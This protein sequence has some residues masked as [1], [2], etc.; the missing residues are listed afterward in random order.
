MSPCYGQLL[1]PAS[2]TRE[3][4]SAIKVSMKK[5]LRGSSALYTWPGRRARTKRAS[6]SAVLTEAGTF[7][8][9]NLW[10]FCVLG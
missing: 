4:T 10:C 5:S 1:W 3:S 7:R 2:T 8:V 9:L 6:A